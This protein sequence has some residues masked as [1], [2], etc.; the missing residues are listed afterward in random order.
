MARSRKKIG[1]PDTLPTEEAPRHSL[2]EQISFLKGYWVSPDEKWKARLLL[3]GIVA[4]TVAN[5]ALTAGV[6]LGF[7]MALNALIAKEAATFAIAGAA[8]AAGIGA[9]A[10]ASNGSDYMTNTLTLNWRG[11]MT[12]QFS[13]AWLS[14]KAYLKLQHN[15]NYTQNPDQRITETV[16][17]VTMSTLSLGLGLV[18]SAVGVAVFSVVLW[19]ISPLMVGAA[20]VCALGSYAATRWAGGSM[21]KIWGA[22]MDVEAKFR[23][24]LARV[25]DNAKSIALAGLEPVEKETLKEKFNNVDATRRNFNK[26]NFRTGLVNTVNMSSASIV[27]IALSAPKFFAGAGTLGELELA[28]QMYGQ[29]YGALNWF[30]QGYEQIASWGANVNQLMEFKKDLD[31]NKGD[32][33]APP[34]PK[35]EPALVKSVTA[36]PKPKHAP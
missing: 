18:R 34:A 13:D 22:M 30:P 5:I 17:N 20:A 15:K 9:A 4:L 16:A 1:K 35:A 12:R 25:R 3:G 6:G 19:H 21:R 10:L 33:T 2:R 14:G 28:R 8:T 23:H 26:V 29:F 11:W 32:I 24:S 7:Q 27:P 36:K 31:E